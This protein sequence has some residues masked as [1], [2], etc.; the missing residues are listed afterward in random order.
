M[1]ASQHRSGAAANIAPQ[2]PEP[3]QV[4]SLTRLHETRAAFDSVAEHYD[5]PSGNNALIQDM[6]RE[7]WR[8]LDASFTPGSRLLDIGCGTGLD[9]VRLARAGY[10]I[11]ATD[12]SARMIART[13]ERAMR[14]RL[15]GRVEALNLGAHE[16]ARIAAGGSFDGAYSNLGALNCVPD[17][18]ALSAECARLLRPGGRLVFAVIGRVCPWE[19]AHYV[20]R[21][22]WRRI[23]VRY[24]AGMTPVG[25]N[26]QV[27]WTRYYTPREFY[28]GFARHFT[29]QGYRGLGLFVPPPYLAGFRERHAAWY[30]W[31][32]RLERCAAGWPGLRSLGDHFL[33]VLQRR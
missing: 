7:V 30:E 8:A 25:M 20:R 3:P 2:R 18:L 22:N 14:E 12:W 9:A 33:M 32:W 28:R 1:S 27:V 6:R 29:L 15:A 19:I 11:T 23:A 13:R 24:A 4:P 17:P 5:G 31:L 26:G 16:L 21:R 10:D